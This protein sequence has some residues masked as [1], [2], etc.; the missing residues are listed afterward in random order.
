VANSPKIKLN[1]I[2]KLKTHDGETKQHS[3]FE[4]ENKQII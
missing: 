1:L 2:E 3:C 4:N